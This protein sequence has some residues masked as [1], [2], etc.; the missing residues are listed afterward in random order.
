[1][2]G[3]RVYPLPG[4]YIGIGIGDK[5]IEMDLDTAK[6]LRDALKIAVG[7]EE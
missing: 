6:E 5:Y 2:E 4:G 7:S 3:V 1:M